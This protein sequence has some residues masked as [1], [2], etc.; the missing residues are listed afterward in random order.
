MKIE[1]KLLQKRCELIKS[2]RSFDKSMVFLGPR[3]EQS[4]LILRVYVAIDIYQPALGLVL[5]HYF[6]RFHEIVFL[7]KLPIVRPFQPFCNYQKGT[8]TSY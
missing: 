1:K 7:A 6:Q 2:Q 3:V 5:R 4:F 8:R